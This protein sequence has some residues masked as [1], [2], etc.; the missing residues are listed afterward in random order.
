MSEISKEV[1]ELPQATR[2]YTAGMSPG[3]PVSTAMAHKRVM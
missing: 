3:I 1:T 2:A